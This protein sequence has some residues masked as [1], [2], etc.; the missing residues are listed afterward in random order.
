MSGGGTYSLATKGAADVI[1]LA[2]ELVLNAVD[3]MRL[4]PE[5]PVFRMTDM[6]CADGGT[7]LGMVEKVIERVGKAART[8]SSTSSIPTS[9]ATTSTRLCK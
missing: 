8:L 2:T 9:P 7:S 6:G 4:R 5:L 3:D 1:H